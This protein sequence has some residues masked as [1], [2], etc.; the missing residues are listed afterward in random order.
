LRFSYNPTANWALQVS[1]A[2]IKSP[3]QLH[4]ADDVDRSTASAS[5]HRDFGSAQWQTTLAWGRN[6]PSHGAATNA[7]LL[8]SAVVLSRIH[9]LFGR[10]ERTGKNELFLPGAAL[11]DQSFRAGKL[12]VGYIRDLPSDS[13]F[14]VGIGGL[15]S[16]YSLPG[17]LQ[18]IYG[19]PTSYMLFA[20]VKLN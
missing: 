17:A 19:N 14:K 6:T 20:R 5:Y 3:E 10:A 2:H 11:A 8:E 9:T 15:I 16:R 4:P 1:R 18:P 13:H 12:S 7:Y